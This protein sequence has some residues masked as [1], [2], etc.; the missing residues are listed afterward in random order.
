MST[1][2]M[3]KMGRPR[4]R[5][6]VLEVSYEPPTASMLADDGSDYYVAAELR[7]FYAAAIN[8]DAES[9]ALTDDR[10]R[11]AAALLSIRRAL[12]SDPQAWEACLDRDPTVTR[13]DPRRQPSRVERLG[14]MHYTPPADVIAERVDSL[15]RE[16][17]G[18]WVHCRRLTEARRRHADEVRARSRSDQYRAATT[19]AICGGT[20]G[21]KFYVYLDAAM[22]ELQ[23][24]S[25]LDAVAI[26]CGRD[27]VALV[28]ALESRAL[29]IPADANTANA[30]I[31]AFIDNAAAGRK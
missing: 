31:S 30:V 6:E 26:L 8:A 10:T 19:C 29:A 14:P 24:N 28:K 9:A 5:L 2:A 16:D 18:Y 11:L 23:R 3:K 25:D 4:R 20:N 27:R 13:G 12:A 1:F 21:R 22:V 15:T 17:L 7:E